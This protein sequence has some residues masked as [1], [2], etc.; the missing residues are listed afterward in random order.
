MCF[1]TDVATGHY[2][3]E[4]KLNTQ[5]IIGIEHFVL[6]TTYSKIQTSKETF[7][8]TQMLGQPSFTPKKQSPIRN[9]TPGLLAMLNNYL[10]HL[11]FS[12]NMSVAFS[13][14]LNS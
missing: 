9:L 7:A 12:R 8:Q 2:F 13:L 4:L 11:S 10:C 6:A 5:Y 1:S 14:I 3:I